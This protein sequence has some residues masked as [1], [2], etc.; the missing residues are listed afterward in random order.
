MKFSHPRSKASQDTPQDSAR[1]PGT[2]SNTHSILPKLLRNMGPE[3]ERRLPKAFS[4]TPPSPNFP[5]LEN[6][7]RTSGSFRR[8]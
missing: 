4:T 2:L 6:R 7:A 8:G 3:T 5:E 1:R